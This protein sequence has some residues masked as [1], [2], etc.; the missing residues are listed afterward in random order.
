[1]KEFFF[2][3]TKNSTATFKDKGS[4]FIAFAYP[5]SDEA[6]FKILLQNI[7]RNHTKARHICFAYRLGTDGLV[8][9]SFDDGEPSGSAG[10]PI[11]NVIDA[12]SLTN[13]VIFVV[14]YFGG[15]L[16][17]IPG[18]I[19]AYKTAAQ[20]SLQIIPIETIPIYKSYKL[21]LNYVNL[22]EV[23]SVFK[24]NNCIIMEQRQNLFI[25]MDI[26]VPLSVL[27]LVQSRLSNLY[28]IEWKEIKPSI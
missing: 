11:L 17:G 12:K 2:T 5:M 15:S 14:R 24:N 27:K 25:E 22:N 16:L 1:M 19:N 7:K 23:I 8:Y 28:D 13:T 20:L 18:L 9:R 3:I 26:K 10:K 6:T 4:S 21:F